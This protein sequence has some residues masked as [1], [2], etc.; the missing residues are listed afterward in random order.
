MA[1]EIF[2]TYSRNLRRIYLAEF[3]D[4]HL[5]SQFSWRRF[6]APNRSLVCEDTKAEAR[7]KLSLPVAAHWP[8]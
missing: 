3:I 1:S 5:Q 8:A 6:I 2:D 7:A 4:D